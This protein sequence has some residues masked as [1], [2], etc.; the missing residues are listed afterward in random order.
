MNQA[1]N[2]PNTPVEPEEKIRRRKIAELRKLGINPYPAHSKRTHM[3]REVVDQFSDL[4]QHKTEVT[5]PGRVRTIRAHGK[6]TFITLSDETGQLQMVLKADH[7]GEEAYGRLAFLDNGDFAQFTGTLFVTQKGQ[8]SVDIK[9]WVILT[10]AIRPLPDKWHGL[11]DLEER[12]RRRYL[13][14]IMNPEVR[15]LFNKRTRFIESM[16]NYLSEQH[17]QEVETPVLEQI[18]GGAEANP[19]ITHHDALDINLYL[20][21]SLELHLK[22]MTVA[23]FEKIFEIGRVFRNEGMDRDHLQEFTMME[24]YWSFADYRQLMDF[25]EGMYQRMIQETF[26]SLAT[27]VEGH[28]LNWKGPWP[29]LS[30]T[31]LVKKETGIDLLEHQTVESLKA[32]I[33]TAKIDIELEPNI[34]LGRVTDLLYKKTVR[35]KLMQPCFLIDHPV[36]V[37]PLAKRKEDQPLLTERLQI[38]ALGSELGNGFSELNDPID[39]RERFEAQMKL[40]E[41]GDTEAAML[42][43]DFLQALEHGLPPTAGFGVGI[44][45][46]FMVLAAAPSIRDVVFFPTMRPEQH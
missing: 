37:S 11:Q 24:M 29:R 28:T 9:E 6:L 45:R 46:L 32:A 12:Y 30:Y 1:K 35:P 41:A 2:Q 14:S 26:G 25:V 13:D 20:R 10:K 43:E 17:F 4:E 36:V 39:Q 7:V 33:Q 8:Q 19:F 31:E 42:D 38:V 40:R 16:R 27:K 23:G 21:I 15:E 3:I 18:P 44:D 34:G 22:R 5:L